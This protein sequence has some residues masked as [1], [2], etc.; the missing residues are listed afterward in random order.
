MRLAICGSRDINIPHYYIHDLIRIFKIDVDEIVSGGAK[1]VDQSALDYAI[2]EDIPFK[3]F[4]A[5]WNKHGK[6]AGPIRNKEIACYSDRL[7]VIRY[8]DSKGSLDVASQF[9]KLQKPIYEIVIPKE[10]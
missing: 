5:D 4:E 10:L 1:G 6:A 3:I 8:E 9:R 2:S 7:L